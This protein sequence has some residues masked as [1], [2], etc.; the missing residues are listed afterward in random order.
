MPQAVCGPRVPLTVK[1]H[2]FLIEDRVKQLPVR[3]REYLVGQGW[4]IT[5]LQP[6]ERFYRAR[7]ALTK[8]HAPFT[9]NFDFQNRLPRRLVLHDGH[10][11][12]FQ[13]VCLVR[14]QPGIG[15]E[16]HVVMQLLAG[17]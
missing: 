11:P 13:P 12:V 8:P 16:Q 2:P 1:L 17:P 5:R 9:A 7:R 15:H 14:P 10:V 6:L 4:L 3:L